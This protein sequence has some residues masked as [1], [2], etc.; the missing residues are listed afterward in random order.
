VREGLTSCVI[1]KSSTGS[2]LERR[3]ASGVASGQ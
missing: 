2:S 1:G 3:G